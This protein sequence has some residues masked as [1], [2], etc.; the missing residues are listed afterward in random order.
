M[1]KDTAMNL[2]K[3]IKCLKEAEEGWLWVREVSRRTG[4]HHKTVSRLIDKHLNV[5]IEAQTMEPFNIRMIKLKPNTDLNS[6]FKFL[7]IKE[8]IEER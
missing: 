4:L 6:I 2:V 1:R 3:I 7:A 8:K 5:F